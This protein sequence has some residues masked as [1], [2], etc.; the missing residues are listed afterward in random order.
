MTVDDA[1]TSNKQTN[2]Q[3]IDIV[4]GCTN[5]STQEPHRRVGLGRVV[6]SSS[7]G[8]VMINTLARH[9]KDVGSIPTIGAKFPIFITPMKL[10]PVTMI[11]Y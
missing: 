6:T 3:N 10:I 1:R 11:L 7:L 2:K 8:G 9:A 4:V 5:L